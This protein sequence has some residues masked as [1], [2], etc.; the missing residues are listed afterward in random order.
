M[1]EA[2]L[3]AKVS[4]KTWLPE[5]LET[6]MRVA[7]SE[8]HTGKLKFG[9]ISRLMEMALDDKLKQLA[10][11]LPERTETMEVGSAE[12][13]TEMRRRA[14]ADE[15]TDAE[16]KLCIEM[17]RETRMNSVSGLDGSKRPRAK[18]ATVEALALEDLL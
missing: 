7:L 3:E 10:R 2:S 6:R 16:A 11:K 5:R 4:F 12:W 17:L 8:P 15:A 1:R 18:K 13:W 14:A 9:T